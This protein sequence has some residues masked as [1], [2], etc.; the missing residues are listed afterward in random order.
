MNNIYDCEGVSKKFT[1]EKIPV[2]ALSEITFSTGKNSSLGIIG[3]SGC[4]K[5]TL[6]N[7]LAGLDKPTK[8]IIKYKG[9]DISQMS[10][11]ELSS[12]RNNDLGFVYQFHHLL[13]EF[14]ALENVSLPL[15]ISGE[16]KK[17][18]LKISENF[19]SKVGLDNR[20]NHLPS[21]LSGGE[22]QRAAIAR[23]ISNNPSCLIM[24]EPTGDLDSK[25]ASLIIDLILELIETR[26][27]NL[28][29]ATHDMV[30][31]EQMDNVINLSNG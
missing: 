8:G 10:N 30:F 29:V 4:G 24:D 5:S 15:Q 18:S 13:P 31:A 9:S 1:L 22:R 14:T 23:A 17:D 6:L 27:I 28:I 20:M 16:T 26:K 21:E 19:L 11:E 25:N 7:L 12:W 3:P 2:E